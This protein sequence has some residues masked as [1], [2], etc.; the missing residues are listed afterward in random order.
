MPGRKYNKPYR[1][2]WA[3]LSPREKKTVTKA[4]LALNPGDPV[5]VCLDDG[6]YRETRVHI[7]PP[8]RYLGN[9]A[10]LIRVIGVS[11]VV[12]LDQVEPLPQGKLPL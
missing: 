8:F 1:R 3:G 5:R 9:G 2:K 10:W 7:G 4:Q 6:S 11:G 12:L